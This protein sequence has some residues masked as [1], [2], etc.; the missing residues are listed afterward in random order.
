MWPNVRER[1]A[2]ASA[3]RPAATAGEIEAESAP[4][5]D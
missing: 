4:G 3:L 2:I 5:G 1:V